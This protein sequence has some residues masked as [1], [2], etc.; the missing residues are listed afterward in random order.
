MLLLER[1]IDLHLHFITF[2]SYVTFLDYCN[3]VMTFCSGD[4]GHYSVRNAAPRLVTEARWRGYTTPVLKQL[5]RLPVQWRVDCRLAVLVYKPGTVGQPSDIVLTEYSQLLTARLFWL[6]ETATHSGADPG[7][8]FV[9][10]G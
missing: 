4:C 1:L 9:G 3:S 6:Y 10:F 5:H 2:T 7:G 8:W